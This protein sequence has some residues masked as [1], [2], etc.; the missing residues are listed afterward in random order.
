MKAIEFSNLKGTVKGNI[1]DLRAKKGLIADDMG[2][3]IL[4]KFKYMPYKVSNF[5]TY[6]FPKGSHYNGDIIH[7]VD[8][9]I[10]FND[11]PEED[12]LNLKGINGR[13]SYFDYTIDYRCNN[14]IDNNSIHIKLMDYNRPK[15]YSAPYVDNEK[16]IDPVF[17]N[18]ERDLKSW[19]RASERGS[20]GIKSYMKK[21]Y[22]N[23]HLLGEDSK[24]DYLM[25]IT[26]SDPEIQ[27][28][29]IYSKLESA[30]LINADSLR[31]QIIAILNGILGKY[32]EDPIIS[33]SDFYLNH[34]ISNAFEICQKSKDALNPDMALTKYP[35]GDIIL[36][37]P[38]HRLISYLRFNRY[39][40]LVS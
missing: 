22:C 2:R 30:Y 40:E 15:H 32:D 7:G 21:F 9:L 17:Q 14:F 28:E 18:M 29:K 36:R 1:V 25:Y 11:I 5:E 19:E 27:D 35:R 8:D 3:Q 13:L 6:K 23:N 33:K 34:K 31:N 4:Q 12:F 37:I 10:N 16:L 26:Y 20:E 24:T 38:K 39:G